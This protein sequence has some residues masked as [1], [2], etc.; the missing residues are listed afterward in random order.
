M[1]RFTVQRDGGEP[2]TA[3]A[4]HWLVAL[5]RALEEAGALPDRTLD[6][7]ADEHGWTATA[8]GVRWTV[9][10]E[11]EVTRRGWRQRI[12]RARDPA[13]A[14][15][16]ALSAAHAAI[17]CESGAV[18]QL[19]QGVLRFLWATGPRSTGLVGVRL[20]ATSGVA[21]YVVQTQRTTLVREAARHPRHF[22]ELDRITGHVTRQMLAAPVFGK[23][24]LLGVIELI[25]PPEERPFTQEDATRLD[26]IARALG[27]RLAGT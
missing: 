6:A 15:R 22:D 26:D 17:P 27:A 25:N 19:E 24:D 21:G 18:L 16:T 5:T 20:P 10:M 9:R 8:D 13:E 23:G 11:D 3:E 7:R 2:R 12:E 1:A 4:A 14:A